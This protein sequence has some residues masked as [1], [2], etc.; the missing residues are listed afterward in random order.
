MNAVPMI[1]RCVQH[2]LIDGETPHWMT[3]KQMW[4]LLDYSD[5]SVTNGPDSFYL[6]VL[7]LYG[8]ATEGY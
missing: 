5:L 2:Q 3:N 4:R 7:K 6:P 8:I 1:A